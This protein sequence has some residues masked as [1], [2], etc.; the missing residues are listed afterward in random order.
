MPT[1]IITLIALSWVRLALPAVNAA[2]AA[3]ATGEI[4][5]NPS[6]RGIVKTSPPPAQDGFKFHVEISEIPDRVAQ[7]KYQT[8]TNITLLPP[9]SLSANSSS[10]K[11]LGGWGMCWN[12]FS[13]PSLQFSG[14]VDANCTGILPRDCLQALQL[15][16]DAKLDCKTIMIPSACL[17][18][19][20]G[21]T[22]HFIRLDMPEKAESGILMDYEYNANGPHNHDKT[23]TSVYEKA[24]RQV[25]V[26]RVSYSYNETR[27][28]ELNVS[29][30]TNT[31]LPGEIKCLRVDNFSPGSATRSDGAHDGTCDKILS[32]VV[33]GLTAVAMLV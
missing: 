14:E 21:A 7:N 26:G 5:L 20:D 30:A 24:I 19:F 18:T 1:S 22:S 33:V 10:A 8:S 2:N 9:S 13:G 25:I 4:M 17:S 32:F 15:E 28:K 16:A 29:G 11:A 27:A 31:K 6:Y 12:M 3:N 23:D